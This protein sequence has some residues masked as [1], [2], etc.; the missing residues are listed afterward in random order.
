MRRQAGQ[1]PAHSDF[2]PTPRQAQTGA[3]QTGPGKL[4]QPV[5]VPAPLSRPPRPTGKRVISPLLTDF[6]SG[7]PNMSV[8]LSKHRGP[9]RDSVMNIGFSSKAVRPRR[10]LVAGG[11]LVSVL[12]TGL[13][14]AALLPAGCLPPRNPP[15]SYR[16]ARHVILVIGDGMHLEHEIAAS[17]YLHGRDRALAWHS[18]S[19]KAYVTTWDV[20][21]YN[22]YAGRA[23]AAPYSEGDFAPFLGYDPARGGKA[24]FPDSLEGT[25][26]YFLTRLPLKEQYGN[27]PAAYPATDSASAAT[28]MA[29]GHKT[30]AGNIS[31][32]RGGP[33]AGGLQTISELLDRKFGAELGIVTTVPFT[34]ATVAAFASH[35][36]SRH[37]YYTGRKGYAGR[38]IA[39][40]IIDYSKPEVVIGG[41]HPAWNNPGFDTD[42]GYISKQAYGQLQRFGDYVLV[43][44]IKGQPA[45]TALAAGLLRARARGKKLFGL[46]GGADGSFEHRVPLNSPGSPAVGRATMENPTLAEA[47][48]CALR[49]LRAR[50]KRFL[51]V[52][53]QGDIDWA[54]HRNDY[55]WMIGAVADL[56]EAVDQAVRFVDQPDDGID[57]TNTLLI[58]TSDH[59]N[60]YMRLI[61]KDRLKRGRLPRQVR[62]GERW[63]YPDGEVSYRS[64]KHTNELVTVY[65]RGRG[66]RLLGRYAG[67]RYR[68]TRILDNTD[69]YRIMAEACG[70][71]PLPQ[72]RR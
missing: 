58:V 67:R 36:T 42:R 40:E 55:R 7:A 37:N 2:Q 18:F 66:A 4:L 56:D 24:P 63:T 30:D 65:A 44:R 27:R 70:L 23:G 28:A 68:N 46:F 57:W 64:G 21:T 43:E 32:R 14:A 29:T 10:L 54:N 1:A 31:W 69:L 15:Y 62:S 52:I 71:S 12:L 33:P 22:R 48:Q 49:L 45:R 25:E 41:G 38:G 20:D 8:A 47:T 34:H 3:R 19:E 13:L 39:E 60:S 26:R 59:A 16:P 53:E 5:R 50:G 11:F 51:A 61:A 35:N 6:K 72:G 9:D 17:R